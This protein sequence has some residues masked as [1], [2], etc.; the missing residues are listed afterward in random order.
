MTGLTDF[1]AAEWVGILGVGLYVGNYTLI[2]LNH[3]RIGT[4]WYFA[5]NGAAACCVLYSLTDAFNI[6]SLLIQLFYVVLSLI[7]MLA[8]LRRR[9]VLP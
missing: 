9:V 5:M 6:A 4:L 3:G 2:T 7:G 8:T 1:T